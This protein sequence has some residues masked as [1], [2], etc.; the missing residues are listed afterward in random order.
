MVTRELEQAYAALSAKSAEYARYWAYHDGLHPQVYADNRL[1]EVFHDARLESFHLNLC[2][3]VVEALDNLISLKGIGVPGDPAADAHLQEVVERERLLWVADGLHEAV[4]VCGEAYLFVWPDEEGRYRL[5]LNRPEQGHVFYAPNDPREVAYAAKWYVDEEG[6]RRLSL[7]YPE[8][9]EF[10][11]SR[12]KAGNVVAA[13]SFEPYGQSPVVEHEMGRVPVFHFRVRHR[14]VSRLRDVVPLQNAVNKLLQD[15][16]VAAEFGA[17]HQRWI[18]SNADLEALKS[19]PGEIWQIPAG[20]EGEQVA[21]GE[22]STTDLGNYLDAMDRLVAMVGAL[23]STP[24]H[25]FF[26]QAGVPSGEALLAMEAPLMHQ[27]RDMIA[28]LKEVWQELFVFVLGLEGYRVAKGDVRVIYEEPRTVQP[29][30][31]AQVRA[32]GVRAGIPLRLLL[33][34]EGWTEAELAEYDEAVR[35]DRALEE[36][37]GDAGDGL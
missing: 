10:Y 11:R 23:T 35:Q 7:Y 25:Y 22:F 18:I 19:R 14:A 31:E 17:F 13:S 12:M 34:R 27:A 3:V 26:G 1:R 9:V 20:A 36:V 15:M 21:V 24:K 5:Y 8:R 2:R 33:K 30:T 6:Y 29:L 37:D 32:Q 16:M 28:R 4:L